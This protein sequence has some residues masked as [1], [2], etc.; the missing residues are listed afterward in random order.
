M[1]ARCVRFVLREIMRVSFAV[2][3]LPKSRL[4]YA[5]PSDSIHVAYSGMLVVA[6]DITPR[7][8]ETTID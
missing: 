6:L 3:D 8:P 2:V 7:N 5:I 1:P 4:Y